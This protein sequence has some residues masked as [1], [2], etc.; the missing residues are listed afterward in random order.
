MSFTQC[1]LVLVPEIHVLK[2]LSDLEFFDQPNHFLQVVSLLTRDAQLV[3]LKEVIGLGKELKITQPQRST[4]SS[5][6]RP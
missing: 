2:G 4:V 6:D 5:A 3:A 1:R